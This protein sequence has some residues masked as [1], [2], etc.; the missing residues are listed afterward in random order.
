MKKIRNVFKTLL[1]V[2]MVAVC[3]KVYAATGSLSVSSGSVYVGDSFT[4]SVTISGASWDVH[5]SASG[6][7]TNCS[8][9]QA[10][11]SA[12]AQDTSRTFTAN[13]VTTGEGTVTVSLSGDVTGAADDYAT[14]ISGSRTVTVSKKPEP[15]PQPQQQTQTTTT[16]TNNNTQQQK[17][18]E[19]PKSNNNK[20]KEISVEGY[21]LVKVDDN[22]YTLAVDNKVEKIT[23]KA[24]A[25]DAKA[26]VTGIGEKEL[27]VGDNTIEV[28]VKAED[29][30]ENKITIKVTRK[31][32]EKEIT[33]TDDTKKTTKTKKSFT[34]NILVILL[35]VID[36]ILSG[37][38][39]WLSL[40]NNKLR[41]NK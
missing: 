1:L 19:T 35:F 39:I 29:G 2:S 26:T 8:I 37:L 12:D 25:E 15:T 14:T 3:T 6:P 23:V 33:K 11:A 9:H 22:N 32:A 30:T 27:E 38:V 20:V 36:L 40:V 34:I 7:V 4:T 5:V 41:K 13:C 17:P 24:T 18:E 28:V 31:E 21:K 10:D 16:T